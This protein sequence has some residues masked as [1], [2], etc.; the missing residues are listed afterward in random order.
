MTIQATSTL[1]KKG[2]EN[3]DSPR[4]SG[5]VNQINDDGYLYR[6]RAKAD[7]GDNRGS[8]ADLNKAIA[9]NPQSVSAYNNR[10]HVK[11]EMGDNQ[12]A[13]DYNKAI[14]IDPQ[15]KKA[16][17]NVDWSSVQESRSNF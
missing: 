14:V 6:A 10:G 7:L 17:L 16:Y 13:I 4:Q 2:R 15:F 9:I 1:G 3:C 5:I 8:I 12:G 11:F